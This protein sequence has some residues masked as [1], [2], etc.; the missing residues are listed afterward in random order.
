MD[1]VDPVGSTEGLVYSIGN[2][3]IA[4]EGHGG[5]TPTV[6]TN[7]G[8]GIGGM[9]DLIQQRGIDSHVGSAVEVGVENEIPEGRHV[10]MLNQKLGIPHPALRAG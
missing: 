5:L 3:L 6:E 2:T 7:N 8:P 1:Y 10:G 9:F 4:A